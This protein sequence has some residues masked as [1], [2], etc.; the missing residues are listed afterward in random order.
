MWDRSSERNGVLEYCQ[1]EGLAFLPWSPLGGSK[2]AGGAGLLRDPVAFPALNEVAKAKGRTP[3]ATLLAWMMAKWSCV[4]HITSA[5]RPAHLRDSLTAADLS[6]TADEVRIR[7]PVH[8]ATSCLSRFLSLQVT[9]LTEI[10]NNSLKIFIGHSPL[11]QVAA[12]D[13][14]GDQGEGIPPWKVV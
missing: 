13:A 5:R 6:L 12:I 2:N 7:T 4:I 3:E 1:S 14:D 11:L 8:R 10:S 9:Q